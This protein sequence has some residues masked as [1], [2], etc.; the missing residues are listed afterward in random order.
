MCERKEIY[1]ARLSLANGGHNINNREKAIIKKN[2]R[3]NMLISWQMQWEQSDKGRWTHTLIP[4]VKPWVNRK[5]G[6]LNYHLTQIFSGHGDFSNYLY[7]FHRRESPMCEMCN[8]C[9][10]DIELT[11]IRC[12]FWRNRKR[13]QSDKGRWTHILIPNVKSLVNRKY[14]R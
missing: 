2:A 11:I 12:N 9:N 3:D 7:R 10:D 6:E 1:N 5:Y 4:N 13:E 14:L 8:D